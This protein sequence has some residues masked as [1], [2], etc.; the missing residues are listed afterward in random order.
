MFGHRGAFINLQ[1]S[2]VVSVAAFGIGLR[3]HRRSPQ[4]IQCRPGL[5][6]FE[7]LELLWPRLGAALSQNRPQSKA[8]F[9][10]AMRAAF[11]SYPKERVPPGI[12]LVGFQQ[13]LLTWIIEK[14]KHFL[15]ISVASRCAAA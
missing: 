7:L 14:D 8:L 4:Q 6:P 12:G 3:T 9:W 1:S 2:F 15:L 10:L 13:F 11:G 5:R